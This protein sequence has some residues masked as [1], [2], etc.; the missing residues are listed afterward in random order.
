MS[1]AVSVSNSRMIESILVKNMSMN[2]TFEK[3]IF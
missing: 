3:Q 1:L 2:E